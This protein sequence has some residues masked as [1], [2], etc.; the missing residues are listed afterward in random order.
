MKK[1]DVFTITIWLKFDEYDKY[2]IT[3]PNNVFTQI[4]FQYYNNS[5]AQLANVF[6][7]ES[8]NKL[9]FG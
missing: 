4:I 7:Q 9:S 6:L 1:L 8:R 5:I 3:V 2:K